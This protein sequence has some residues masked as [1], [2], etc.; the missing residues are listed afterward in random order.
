MKIIGE[1]LPIAKMMFVIEKDHLPDRDDLRDHPDQELPNLSELTS[2]FLC[3][4]VTD[5]KAMKNAGKNYKKINREYKSRY[6]NGDKKALPELL[7]RYP[8]FWFTNEPWVIKALKEK[9]V[10]S[11]RKWEDTRRIFFTNLVDALKEN[12][13]NKDMIF[14]FL[15]QNLLG[16]C[17]WIRRR[18]DDTKKNLINKPFAVS[19][20]PKSLDE[21]DL[22]QYTFIFIRPGLR[23]GF[24]E[25]KAIMAQMG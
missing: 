7:E 13:I 5:P 2:K 12:G 21:H 14:G 19:S 8:C 10:K 25:A 24:E 18:Y 15:E 11:G 6:K 17:S 20:I 23:I 9:P 22:V 1:I 16:E 3:E 4:C